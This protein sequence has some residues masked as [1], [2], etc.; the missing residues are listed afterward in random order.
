M[1]D[2]LKL[3]PPENMQELMDSAAKI[4]KDGGNGMYRVRVRGSRSWATIHPGFL[5][6]Y[7]NFGAHNFTLDGG[8]LKS[9]VNSK[10]S[11]GCTA[12]FVKMV[13]ESGS[14]N[15]STYT[16]YQ[17]G[18]DLGAGASGMIYDADTL[19]Y[20]TNSGD[21][22]MKGQLAYAPIA[23]NP[24]AQGP[25]S[26]V[27]I[28]P[29]AMSNFSRN[30]GAAWYFMQWATGKE[31]LLFGARGKDMV[32]PV[33]ASVF[34]DKQVQSRVK[35]NFPG[36]LDAYDA[37]VTNAKI[38]FTLQPLFF[39]VAT[40]WASALQRMVAKQVAVSEGLDQLAQATDRQT[41]SAGLG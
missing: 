28:W 7:T 40:D 15:W 13:Q 38:Y 10:E 9:A 4:T 14:K 35:Q 6:G 1:F 5:S 31:H 41:H 11:K 21:T 17:V 3:Q 23:P 36:Y 26:K 34:K 29:L 27:W 18:A 19:G 25:T 16:W 32:V 2:R 30:K 39:N 24:S 37:T 12:Q 8:K 20:F 33:R 22:K